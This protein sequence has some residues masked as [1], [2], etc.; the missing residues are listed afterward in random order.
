MRSR[1]DCDLGQRCL[2]AGQG[3]EQHTADLSQ[4]ASQPLMHYSY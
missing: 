2:C 1:I 4:S 3:A